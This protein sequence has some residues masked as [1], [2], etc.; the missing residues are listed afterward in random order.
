MFLLALA[1][2]DVKWNLN[3]EP[4]PFW[5]VLSS[6]LSHNEV[7]FPFTFRLLEWRWGRSLLSVIGVDKVLSPSNQLL[8][9]FF[10][11]LF[12][13]PPS[14]SLF[15]GQKLNY[16]G[17]E[18][19]LRGRE[20]LDGRKGSWIPQKGG[21]NTISTTQIGHTQGTR[22]VTYIQLCLHSSVWN[23]SRYSIPTWVKC[24]GHFIHSFRLSFHLVAILV[25]E[26]L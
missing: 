18:R 5:I 25:V 12:L 15:Y 23:T 13:R 9:F 10:C 3:S 17:L 20:S 16:K 6:S 11:F 26:S 22:I 14:F 8:S 1:L 2:I 19:T 4:F 24:Q 21:L 7:H